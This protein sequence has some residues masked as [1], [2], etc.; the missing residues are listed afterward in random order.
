M[1][2]ELF[3]GLFVAL[4]KEVVVKQIKAIWFALFQKKMVSEAR[5]ITDAFDLYTNSS[6]H[7]SKFQIHLTT[8][9]VL[10]CY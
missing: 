1:L 8:P 10:F 2:S 5:K 9:L 3:K 4:V 7:Y 6:L